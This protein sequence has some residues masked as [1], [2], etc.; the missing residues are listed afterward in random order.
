MFIAISRDGEALQRANVDA[1]VTLDALGSGEDCLHVAVEATLDF[2]SNLGGVEA[3]FYLDVQLFK[4][5]RQI[6]MNHLLT[7]Y[8]VVIVVIAPLTESHLLAHQVHPDRRTFRQ[9][10]FLAPVVNG[11]GR[12]MA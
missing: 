8:R 12:L 10:N 6:D 9:G 2:I 7:S 5:L 1:C 3:E 4:P 11:D